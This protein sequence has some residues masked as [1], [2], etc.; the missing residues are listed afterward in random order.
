MTQSILETFGNLTK[1]SLHSE[2]LLF[3]FHKMKHINFM[4]YTNFTML[5]PGGH[6][7]TKLR[8]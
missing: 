7:L 5:K 1:S 3:L 6:I 2:A 8:Y 4:K